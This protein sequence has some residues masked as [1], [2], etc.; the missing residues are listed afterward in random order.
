VQKGYRIHFVPYVAKMGVDLERFRDWWFHQVYWDQNTKSANPAGFFF[1]LLIR[2]IPFALIY[3]LAG[4]P[5]GWSVVLATIAIRLLT[6]VANCLLLRD[7]DGI[8]SVWL[9]PIR[10][11]LG[12][13][14]WLASFFKRKTYW[15]EKIF[16]LKRGRMIEVK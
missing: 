2:G 12:I 14:V 3:A 16:V 1:T 6:A 13:F 10:D 7:P 15:K 4:G 8:K 9:L 5:R 11:L